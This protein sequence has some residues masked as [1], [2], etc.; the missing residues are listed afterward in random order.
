MNRLLILTGQPGSGKTTL[1][2]LVKERLQEDGE[3]VFIIDGDEMRQLH[4][5][6]DYTD[7]GRVKNVAQASV[8]AKKKLALGFV[9]IVAM[10]IPTNS[11][12]DRLIEKGNTAVFLIE[13]SE[14]RGREA[15]FAS[16]FEVP[17]K[18]T[19][20]DTDKDINHCVALILSTIKSVT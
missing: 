19:K 2:K 20:V 10:V 8:L 5:N 16:P 4:S 13:T 18:F 6:Y 9:V 7:A 3:S 14:I 1:S 11:L 15:N 17:D 12:R